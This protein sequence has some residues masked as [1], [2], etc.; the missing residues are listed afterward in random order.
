[1]G[2]RGIRRVVDDVGWHLTAA[3][4]VITV[5]S[6]ANNPAVI[7]VLDILT[8]RHGAVNRVIQGG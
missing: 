2:F 1:M 8:L 4:A 6:S 5:F 7:K 3:A